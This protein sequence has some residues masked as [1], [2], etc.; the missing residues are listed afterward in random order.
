[1]IRSD[2]FFHQIDRHKIVANYI[3]NF[4]PTISILTR[5]FV[6]ADRITRRKIVSKVHGLPKY[7]NEFNSKQTK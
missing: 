3:F 7:E 1:M 6:I 4:S 2:R 5:K